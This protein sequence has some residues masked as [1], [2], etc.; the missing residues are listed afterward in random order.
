[1][2]PCHFDILTFEVPEVLQYREDLA[3]LGMVSDE[4]NWYVTEEWAEKFRMHERA[5]EPLA[6]A[7]NPLAQYSIAAIYLLG[8]KYS[9]LAKCS[10]NYENDVD[11]MTAWLL[12]AAR[13]GMTGA[14]DTLIS[15]GRGAEV[16]RLRGIAMQVHAERTQ[17]IE[18]PLGETWRRAYG[19]LLARIE[20]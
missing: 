13:A 20:G 14:I 10:A 17:G 7:G 15:S 2:Y 12:E 5:L 4:A 16:E 18:H 1:M 3:S 9:S 11:V 19:D 6:F 8:V